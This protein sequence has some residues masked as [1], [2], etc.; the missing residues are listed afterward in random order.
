MKKSTILVAAAGAMT[1]L[2]LSAVTS[3]SLAQPQGG[4]GMGQGMHRGMGG[5][6][7]G[8]GMH[9]GMGQR[10]GHGGGREFCP[11]GRKH[12]GWGRSGWGHGHGRG[13]G[14]EV[15]FKRFDTDKDG[16]LTQKEINDAREALV[17]KH[18]A[19]KNGELSLTEFQNLWLEVRHKRM[20]RA[21]QRLDEDGSAGVT[22]AE[23]LEP[24][25][26]VV[27][28]RDR[29]G[30]GVLDKEDRK[31]RGGWGRG[32]GQDDGPAAPPAEEN[33]QEN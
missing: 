23:F 19:D 20:V 8:P 1:L 9:H 26:N 11:H 32:R 16:K 14:G 6:G 4:P 10:M 22:T 3:Y 7:M 24:F 30:D 33:T 5:Q 21:F 27:E 15:L 28:R 29:N 12:G 25:A 18:D 2:G 31:R 13:K 17:A